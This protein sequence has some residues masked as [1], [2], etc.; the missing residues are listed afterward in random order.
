MARDR[1]LRNRESLTDMGA[2]SLVCAPVLFADKVL[3]LIHLYCTDPLKALDADDLEFTVAVAK[4]LGGV[5]HNLNRTQSLK[6]ENR[7]L[8][9][10]LKVESE[11][12]GTSPAMKELDRQISLVAGTNATCLI[13]GESGVGKELAARAVHYS[14]QRRDGPFVT[15][16][17]AA[18]TETLLESELFGHEKGSLHRGDGGD[19]PRRVRGRGQPWHGVPRRDRRAER[20]SMQPKLL[21]ASSKAIAWCERVGGNESVRARRKRVISAANAT[22]GPDASEVNRGRSSARDLFCTA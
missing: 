9:D 6:N 5:I 17:C 2:T 12:V 4:Q 1:L 22:A 18:L 11:M 20:S 14:S 7:T 21:R 13:R 16:N 10:Q 8:R 15:L 3:G 19:A